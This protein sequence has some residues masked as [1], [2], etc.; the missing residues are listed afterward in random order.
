MGAR[1]FG[2]TA[3]LRELAVRLAQSLFKLKSSHLGLT[4]AAAAAAATAGRRDRSGG[5]T[6][7]GQHTVH[8]V[9]R[10]HEVNTVVCAFVQHSSS[11]GQ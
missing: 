4:A 9:M 3:T 5:G 10:C 6:S 7:T 1:A 2:S 8:G 11:L